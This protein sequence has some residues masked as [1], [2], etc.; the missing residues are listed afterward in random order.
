M[1][2]TYKLKS[3]EV[4][5]DRLTIVRPGSLPRTVDLHQ[6]QYFIGRSPNNGIVLEAPEVSHWHVCL[7]P[8]ADGWQCIDLRSSSGTHLNQRRLAPNVAETWQPGQTLRVGP[9][10]LQWLPAV[11]EHRQE[12]APSTDGA[13]GAGT[14]L[15][16]V[17][18]VTG[19]LL[20]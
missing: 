7:E 15:K 3:T 11:E 16:Q 20:V 4:K 8:T 6:Q 14:K 17:L 2:N 9:Y 13:N 18:P 1:D 5:A 10:L 19:I 12:V